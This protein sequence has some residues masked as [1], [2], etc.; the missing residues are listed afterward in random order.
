MIDKYLEIT[1]KIA[2]ACGVFAAGSILLSILIVTELVFERY[3]FGNAIT[4]QTELVTMLLVAS[5]FIGSA[6]V[7]AENGHV[8]MDYFYTFLSKKG[9]IILR[10]FTSIL[11]LIFFLILF[12]VSYE[13]VSEAFT[14]NYDT[15]TVWGPPLWIPYSSMLIGAVLMT[16]A[17]IGELLKLFRSLGELNQ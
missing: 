6:Y 11:C 14:K 16:M 2:T 12:Y 4:W 9:V 10:I 13:I 17:Y 8:N 5:T 7:F 3:I 1:K 15:G